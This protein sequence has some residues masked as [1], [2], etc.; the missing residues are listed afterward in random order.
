MS[1]PVIIIGGGIVG[2]SAAYFLTEFGEKV[3][4]LEQ[5]NIASGASGRNGG[6]IMKIDGR[7]SEPG[8]ILVRIPYVM[9]NGDHIPDIRHNFKGVIFNIHNL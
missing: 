1:G 8:P 4:L 9:E 5:R 3:I 2:A 7:D 6:M